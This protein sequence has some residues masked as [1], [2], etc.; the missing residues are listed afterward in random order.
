MGP[1]QGKGLFLDEEFFDEGAQSQE[2]ERVEAVRKK[3]KE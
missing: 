3:R 2:T 1:G